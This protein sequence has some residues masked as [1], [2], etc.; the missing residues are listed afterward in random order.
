MYIHRCSAIIDLPEDGYTGFQ[1]S[2][3]QMENKLKL[4]CFASKQGPVSSKTVYSDK[5]PFVRQTEAADTNACSIT[6]LNQFP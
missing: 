6:N 4:G 1:E 2:R 3:L 5:I